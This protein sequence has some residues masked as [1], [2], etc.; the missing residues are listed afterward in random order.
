MPHIHAWGRGALMA[1]TIQAWDFSVLQWIR[2][3]FGSDGMDWW[4]P[5]ITLLG[6]KGLLWIA[7]TL[8]CLALPARRRCG[9]AMAGGLLAGL[10]LGNGLLKHLACRARPCWL[11]EVPMLIAVPQDYSFPSCH[12]LSSFCAATVLL[13]YDRRLGIPAMVAAVLVAFSRL[14]LYVHFPTDVLAGML[15]GIG[16]GIASILVNE[17]VWHRREGAPE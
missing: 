2:N 11:R 3:V 12:T 8:L 17:A 9:T 5:K 16:L 7:L 6:D 10:L 14:Y 15:L 4:M 13:Y 1:E